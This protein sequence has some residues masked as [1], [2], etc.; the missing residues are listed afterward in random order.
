MIWAVSVLVFCD[1][2]SAATIMIE[3][4]LSTTFV[5]GAINVTVQVT[6][7]TDLY[8]YQF[9]VSFDP[10]VLS[11]TDVSEGGLLPSGGGTFFFPGAIDNVLGTLTL[12]SGSLEGPVPG[13]SGS[14]ILANIVFTG[15][16]FGASPVTL[17]N[18]VLLDSAGRDIAATTIQNGSVTVIPEPMSVMLVGCGVLGGLI[19]RAY[20]GSLHRSQGFLR[21]LAP[22]LRLGRASLSDPRAACRRLTWPDKLV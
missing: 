12:T 10:T 9:D 5:G 20:R 22:R 14:G 21:C 16:G 13:V 1:A 4:T 19:A 6:D 15:V 17:S 8:A 11:T 18:V 7:V 3:P 2:A